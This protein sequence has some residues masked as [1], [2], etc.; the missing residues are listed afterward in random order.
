M[1]ALDMVGEMRLTKKCLVTLVI[2]TV[3]GPL[4]GMRPDMLIEAHGTVKSLR[5]VLVG[6]FV[7]FVS[8]WAFVR[9]R[10]C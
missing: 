10:R 7:C 2:C 6:A 4:V 1:R 5:A 8:S 3:E 9:G